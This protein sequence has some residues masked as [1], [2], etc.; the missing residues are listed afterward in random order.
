LIKDLES[1]GQNIRSFVW[2]QLKN[3]RSLSDETQSKEQQWRFFSR[4]LARKELT[5]DVVKSLNGLSED[6]FDFTQNAR[7]ENQKLNSQAL[8]R[9]ISSVNSRYLEK[10]KEL[11][12][13]RGHIL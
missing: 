5:T 10:M 2:S 7:T 6:S 4:N 11:F 12:S 13:G 1:I 3:A 8:L 9:D